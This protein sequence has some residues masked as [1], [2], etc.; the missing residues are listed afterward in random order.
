MDMTNYKMIYKNKIY[1]CLQIFII[2]ANEEGIK[3]IEVVYLNE[4]NRL[5]KVRDKAEE[6][7]FVSK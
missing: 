1:N 2:M 3:E 5:T 6:F 7:Q 4:E